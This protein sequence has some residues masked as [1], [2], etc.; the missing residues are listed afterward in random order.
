MYV[1]RQ[2]HLKYFNRMSFTLVTKY[3][4]C[5]DFPSLTL[6]H[7]RHHV[8]SSPV[9]ASW[10]LAGLSSQEWLF[11]LF[12]SLFFQVLVTSHSFS[13]GVSHFQSLLQIINHIVCQLHCYDCVTPEM[14][15]CRSPDQAC[16]H[17]CCVIRHSTIGPHLIY[18]VQQVH[19][20]RSGYSCDNTR[21]RGS[22]CLEKDD[23][24]PLS[25]LQD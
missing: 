12:G 6:H 14:T 23:S 15:P 22:H 16:I 18:P 5:V 25:T 1:N 17:V 4:S 9:T 20:P 19:F 7:I 3:T 10:K 8:G 13:E 11:L 24:T 2:F 21:L